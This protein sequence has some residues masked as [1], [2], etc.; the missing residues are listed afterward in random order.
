MLLIASISLVIDHQLNLNR[1]FLLIS[2][3]TK[4][5][6][7]QSFYHIHV[8]IIML[9]F[10]IPIDMRFA[11]HQWVY[12]LWPW[13]F[14]RRIYHHGALPINWRSFL[15]DKRF[16]K[17]IL[18]FIMHLLRSWQLCVQRCKLDNFLNRRHCIWRI[19]SLLWEYS[20]ESIDNVLF[21]ALVLLLYSMTFI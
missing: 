3:I 1:Q 10:L 9:S 8:Q 2:R 7:H 20:S 12:L 13:L 14:V 21:D 5:W 15:Y 6:Y 17:I 18:A 4:Y 16:R 11:Q 19:S